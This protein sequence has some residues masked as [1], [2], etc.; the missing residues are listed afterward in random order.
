M[1]MCFRI[2]QRWNEYSAKL[3]TVGWKWPVSFERKSRAREEGGLDVLALRVRGVKGL[4]IHR[5]LSLSFCFPLLYAHSPSSCSPHLHGG[6]DRPG[7]TPLTP[8][9]A[10]SRCSHWVH[11]S[12]NAHIDT[13]AHT[14]YKNQDTKRGYKLTGRGSVKGSFF[15]CTLK[16]DLLSIGA[17]FQS[18]NAIDFPLCECVVRGWWITVRAL[19]CQKHKES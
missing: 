1:Q 15:R 9:A 5:P 17:S 4:F 8:G 13:H 3:T 7:D 16:K 14:N 10:S 11:K 6:R 19:C 12:I 2:Y 18:W